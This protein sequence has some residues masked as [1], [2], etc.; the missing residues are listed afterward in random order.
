MAFHK[1]RLKHGF[2]IFRLRMRSIDRQLEFGLFNQLR[3][4]TS[5]FA[6][7][8]RVGMTIQST[9]SIADLRVFHKQQ[10]PV[11]KRKSRLNL[12]DSND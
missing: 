11:S 2:Q 8:N 12:L 4:L 9:T 3:K 7:W 10:K 6:Y 5:P 1:S